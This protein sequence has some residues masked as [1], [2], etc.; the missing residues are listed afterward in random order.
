MKNWVE[1]LVFA[2]LV[3]L[4]TLSLL[5]SGCSGVKLNKDPSK[6]SITSNYPTAEFYACGGHFVGLGICDLSVG[7]DISSLDLSVQGYYQ[8]RIRVF[9]EALPADITLNYDGLKNIP[10]D[11]TGK[12]KQPV[13]IGITH[14]PRFPNEE[15][16]AIEIYGVIGFLWVNV[17]YPGESWHHYTSK[18]VEGINDLVEIDVREANRLELISEGCQIDETID[19]SQRDYYTVSLFNIVDD[20]SIGQ[21]VIDIAIIGTRDRFLTWLSWRYDR[22]YRPIAIPSWKLSGQEISFKAEKHVSIISVDDEWV[23]GNEADFDFYRMTPHAVRLLTVKG[24]LIV[25]LWRPKMMDFVW[26]R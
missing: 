12:P 18:S 4:C 19:V 13:L 24:R 17:V 25:G 5:M 2:G 9:S 10:I 16:Q 6:P 7:E 22:N 11:L 26:V 1:Y 23:I 3:V 21:C 15:N 8:G 20:L 14:T